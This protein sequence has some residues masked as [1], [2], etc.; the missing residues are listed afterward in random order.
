MLKQTVEYKDYNGATR[1]DTLYFNLTEFELIEIQTES[2]RGIE[3]DLKEAIENED[4]KGILKFVKILV[5]NGY[6]VKSSDG[7]FFEKSP[8]ILNRFVS[9]AAYSPFIMDL[10]TDIQGKMVP[11]INGIMPQ[12]L[13]ERAEQMKKASGGSTTQGE[14]LPNPYETGFSGNSE[15]IAP[16]PIEE[17]GPAPELQPEITDQDQADFLA[18]KKSR[19]IEVEGL[20]RPPHESGQGFQL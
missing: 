9:S 7:R 14:T 20:T 2:E 15:I 5:T 10:F 12:G 3:V 17:V 18:W 19:G 4:T 8:E 11:F 13:I 1:R 16:A 6:G